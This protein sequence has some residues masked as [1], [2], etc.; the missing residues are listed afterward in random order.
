MNLKKLIASIGSCFLVAFLGGIFTSAS[1]STWYVQLEK[2]IFNPPNWVFGPVWSILYFMMG[3]ALYKIWNQKTKSS[4]KEK[5]IG[6]FFIQL[7]L[8]FMW[9]LVFFG[10]R[11]PLLAFI[12]IILLWIAIFVTMKYF[13]RI[14]RNAGI[15]LIPYI[16]W[17]TFASILNLAIVLLNR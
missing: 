8:N 10:L 6:I 2:P 15:L 17:V 5:A 4:K 11:Q 16:L 9:S 14:S 7:S 1:V 12:T 13:W 3:L